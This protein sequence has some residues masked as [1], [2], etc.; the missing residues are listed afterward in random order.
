MD[1]NLKETLTC[2]QR[3]KDWP[4]YEH[5]FR[6]IANL[7]YEI[8]DRRSSATYQREFKL[9]KLNIKIDFNDANEKVL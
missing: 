3:R 2:L 6:V 1:K 4:E 9:G 5:V 7:M 8:G